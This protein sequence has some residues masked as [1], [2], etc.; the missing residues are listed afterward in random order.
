MSEKLLMKGNEALAEAAIRAGCKLFFGYPITPQTELAEYMAKQLPKRDGMCLQA[1]SEVSAINMIYGAAATGSR[2]IT[3]TSSPGVSL[4]SEGIS[5]II[6]S[7][8]PLD[9]DSDLMQLLRGAELKVH[10]ITSCK[11]YAEYQE[12]AESR[13]YISRY[14][15]AKAGGDMLAAR[16][17]GQHCYVPF[18]FDYDEIEAGLNHLSAVL[19]I[20]PPDFSGKR[21]QCRAALAKTL[22]LLGDVPIAIDYT[23][24]PR[25]LGLARL[26]LEAGFNVQRV[27]LDTVTGEEKAAFDVLKE[28]FPELMLYPTVHAGMRFHAEKEPARFLAIGQ[29]AA[30]FCNTPHFVNVVEGGGMLGYQAVLKTLAL[31]REAY[32]EEKPMR[33][34]IQ[35]KGMGCGGCV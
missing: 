13:I 20:V 11:T 18:S 16:L 24:C 2:C 26:L 8:L 34:L 4:M 30:H 27:Y 9:E 6:G 31:M 35:I 21:E 1:E 33:D 3:S 28:R 5:Y 10:E 29:K 25:P 7:D 22:A 12:M 19:G 17:G 15:S 23:Y 32:L 14:P